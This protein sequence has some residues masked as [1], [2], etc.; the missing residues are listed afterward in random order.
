MIEKAFDHLTPEGV[1]VTQFGENE[2]DTQPIRTRYLVTIGA[3]VA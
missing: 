3:A 2:F 1:M